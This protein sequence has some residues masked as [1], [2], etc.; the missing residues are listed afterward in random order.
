MKI[1]PLGNYFRRTVGLKQLGRNVCSLL[2]FEHTA[3]GIVYC[4]LFKFIV[5]SQFELN[6]AVMLQL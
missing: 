1:V 4:F 3:F 2:T 5:T 6:S